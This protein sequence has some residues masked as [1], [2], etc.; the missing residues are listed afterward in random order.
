MTGRS[1]KTSQTNVILFVKLT[2]Y[3]EFREPYLISV[4]NHGLQINRINTISEPNNQEFDYFIAVTYDGAI[5]QS[6]G[7]KF[8]KQPTYKLQSRRL[9]RRGCWGGWTA[10]TTVP[11]HVCCTVCRRNRDAVIRARVSVISRQTDRQTGRE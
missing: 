8:R 9:A 7:R 11:G 2:Y 1:F 4:L 3:A 6:L 5:S 10:T